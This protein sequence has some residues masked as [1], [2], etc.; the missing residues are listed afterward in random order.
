MVRPTAAVVVA[1]S[2]VVFVRD[3]LVVSGR[4]GGTAE[5]QTNAAAVDSPETAPER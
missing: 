2:L 3:Y 1:P 5:P 4:L